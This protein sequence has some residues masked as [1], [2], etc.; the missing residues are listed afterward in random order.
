MK[1]NTTYFSVRYFLFKLTLNRLH[2]DKHLF[3]FHENLTVKHFL[4]ECHDLSQA[5]YRFYCVNSL[6]ELF[7]TIP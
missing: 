6:K 5:R 4:L 3:H 2:L 1:S 7:N